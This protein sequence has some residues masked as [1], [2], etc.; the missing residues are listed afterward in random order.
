MTHNSGPE[1]TEAQ[2]CPRCKTATMEHNGGRW[3]SR[4]GAFA[5]PPDL[6]RTA[7]LQPTSPPP[8]PPLMELGAQRAGPRCVRCGGEVDV[9]S[10][11]YDDGEWLCG[12]C[13]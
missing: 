8:R 4:C 9:L 13:F 3:C 1:G 5:V 7:H 10:G 12:G 6:R 2:A 11:I